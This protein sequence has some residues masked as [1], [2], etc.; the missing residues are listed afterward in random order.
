MVGSRLQLVFSEDVGASIAPEDF[1]LTNHTTGQSVPAAAMNVS[2][3]IPTSTLTITFPGLAGALLDDGEYTLQ[4]GAASITDGANLALDTDGNGPDIALAFYCLGG[5]AD[6]DR[7]VDADDLAILNQDLGE[8]AITFADGDITG[9]GVVNFA[10]LV[11]LAQHYNSVNAVPGDGDINGDGLV[12]FADLTAL[13]QHYNKA[14]RADFNGD[15]VI[16]S[17]DQQILEANLGK[18][19]RAPDAVVATAPRNAPAVAVSRP[20]TFPI[21]PAVAAAPSSTP[22]TATSRDLIPSVPA[23]AGKERGRL[24]LFAASKRPP[25]P[26]KSPMRSRSIPTRVNTAASAKTVTT[27]PM[28]QPPATF[29]SA[30]VRRRQDAAGV[31]ERR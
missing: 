3:D 5:D 22:V 17:A 24:Q 7:D 19:L 23:T 27:P 20:A 9:D 30:R 13:A 8:P 14:G 4:F 29:S 16:N 1:I 15:G 10:D 12:D 6:G 11:V 31:L 2:F 26:N 25:T 28:V 18:S 21:A